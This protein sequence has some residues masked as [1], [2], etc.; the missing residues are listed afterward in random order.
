MHVACYVCISMYVCM[1]VC[2]YVYVYVYLH[3]DADLKRHLQDYTSR[4]S[5]YERQYEAFLKAK[6]PDAAS[7][8]SPTDA[9]I[10]RYVHIY[11]CMHTY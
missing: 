9:Y 8:L 5:E 2:M 7:E 6:D 11:G 3:I 1:Y 10:I 4:K